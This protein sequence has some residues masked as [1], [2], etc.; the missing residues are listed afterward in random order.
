M[1]CQDS[2]GNSQEFRWQGTRTFAEDSELENECLRM[3]SPASALS[4]EQLQET[5]YTMVFWN[6]LGLPP[7]NIVSVAVASAFVV[8]MLFIITLGALAVMS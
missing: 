2:R 6:S 7:P 1:H 5:L 8:A 3:H 4:F